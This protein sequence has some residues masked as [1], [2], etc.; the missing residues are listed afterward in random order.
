ML[1]YCTHTAA[2]PIHLTASSPHQLTTSSQKLRSS[3]IVSHPHISTTDWILKFLILIRTFFLDDG[4]IYAPFTFLQ[5]FHI[6]TS[7]HLRGRSILF[8]HSM[9]SKETE[10]HENQNNSADFQ[11]GVLSNAVWS[12]PVVSSLVVE[13]ELEA[14]QVRGR[15]PACVCPGVCVWAGYWSQSLAAC[16]C[17]AD[18]RSEVAGRTWLLTECCTANRAVGTDGL[19]TDR[20]TDS[21]WQQEWQTAV[22]EAEVGVHLQPDQFIQFSMSTYLVVSLKVPNLVQYFSQ[23]ICFL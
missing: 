23:F 7:Q 15:S 21:K 19:Q 12:L 2:S 9:N 17:V 8:Q 16:C 4:V 18:W 22:S 6:T 3:H 14:A 1:A 20:Q 11:W 10:V 5:M 13:L